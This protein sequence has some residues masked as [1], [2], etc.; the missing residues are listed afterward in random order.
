MPGGTGVG[1][2]IRL[3][4]G[5]IAHLL[6]VVMKVAEDGHC[7]PP[8]AVHRISNILFAERGDDRRRRAVLAD[9]AARIRHVR[10][11]RNALIG[12]PLFRD[13]AW[14]MLLELFAA[15]ENG[16]KMSVSL[17]CIASGVPLTTALRQLQRLEDYGLVTRLGDSSDQRRCLVIPTA[18]AMDGVESVAAAL[19][20]QS[21]A[22]DLFDERQDEAA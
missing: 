9:Y 10:M 18:K 1:E 4:V 13:P 14:D 12:A 11:K 7:T 20:E 3:S 22:A 2:E 21:H 6:D 19:L 15:H 17:L 8:E 16:R 5:E